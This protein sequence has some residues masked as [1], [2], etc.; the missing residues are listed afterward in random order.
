MGKIHNSLAEALEE[1]KGQI[2][3]SQQIKGLVLQM[4]PNIMKSS[5]VVKDH[6]KPFYTI[7]PNCSVCVNDESKRLLDWLEWG[8]YKVRHYS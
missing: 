3:S 8:Q 6:A 5:I 1:H 2:L 7:A 4:F